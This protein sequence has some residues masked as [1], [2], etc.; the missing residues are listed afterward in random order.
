VRSPRDDRADVRQV[1]AERR[2][3][4]LPRQGLQQ[5]RNERRELRHIR[6]GEEAR[7]RGNTCGFDGVLEGRIADELRPG[8]KRGDCGRRVGDHEL[9]AGQLR[10]QLH[11]SELATQRAEQGM[12]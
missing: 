1:V 2:V 4:G 6:V 9:A 8:A 12:R 7:L 11:R 10:R 3:G 5:G